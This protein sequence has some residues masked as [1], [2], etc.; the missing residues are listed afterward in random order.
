MKRVKHGD[1]GKVVSENYSPIRLSKNMIKT[2]LHH[3]QHVL[4]VRGGDYCSSYGNKGFA[5]D[6]VNLCIPQQIQQ[7]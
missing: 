5:G 1:Q 6:S 7:E 4:T 2:P 3:G